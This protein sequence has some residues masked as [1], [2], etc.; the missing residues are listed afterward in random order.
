MKRR[1]FVRAGLATV[2]AAALPASTA[3]IEARPARRGRLNHSACKWC[4]PNLTVDELAAAGAAMGLRSVEL[5]DPPDWPAVKRHGLICAM[6]NPPA[7]P[8]GMHFL[9]HGFNRLEHHEWLV[10]GYL[11]R[12][13]EVAEAGFPNL[14][15]F[16]G[17]RAG[18]DDEEGLENCVTGLKKILPAAERLGV[19]VCMELLNSKVDHPDY[20]CDHTAWGV[21]LVDRLGSDRFKLLYDIY[22]MQIMEGDIIRTIRTYHDYIAHYH[23]GGNPGR[24]E[25]DETQELNYR[26]IAQAIA[27][28]GFTG[29]IAQE[30]IP[31]R[32]PLTSLR[33]A[34]AIC[35]V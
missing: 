27:D 26:A 15:C 24:H 5:L 21:A 13:E 35:D 31:T 28:T 2:A 23:T 22:H 34:L 3:C 14:I 19:T 30:F 4:Y 1:T 8:D 25:I 9:T 32:D 18:L 7:A 6:A 12:L 17:N 11:K 16:S 10:P 33:E 20:Q 29:Y